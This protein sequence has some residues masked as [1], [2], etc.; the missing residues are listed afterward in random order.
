MGTAFVFQVS[1][2]L[3]EVLGTSL[4]LHCAYR[5][6]SS[7]KLKKI[8]KI[9]KETLIKLALE[10]GGDCMMLLPSALY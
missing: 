8:N 4:K 6:Q 7:E 5:P 2:G 10:T 1:Q 9:L 3:A